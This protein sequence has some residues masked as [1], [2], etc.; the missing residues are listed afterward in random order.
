MAV[1][2]AG[3]CRRVAKWVATPSESPIVLKA[4]G[5]RGKGDAEASKQETGT[6][7]LS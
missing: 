7:Y 6:L 3:R 4:H 2:T 1:K 5:R